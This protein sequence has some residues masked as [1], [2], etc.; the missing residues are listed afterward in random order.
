MKL[1]FVFPGQGSQSVGMLSTLAESEP[2]VAETFAEASAVLGYDLWALCARGPAE[3]LNATERTQPALLAAGAAAWR[4]WRA[5]GGREPAVMAGHSLG[6][7]TAL[8]C[9]GALQFGEAVDLV[10]F[11]GEAMQAAVPAGTG[12]MAAI[13]GLDDGA[14]EAACAEAAGDEVVVAVNY[15]APGQVVI[16]GTADAVKRAIE[17]CRRRGAKR[18][19]ELPVSVPS[20]SPLMR[21]AAERFRDRLTRTSLE[22]PRIPVYAFDAGR[23]DSAEAIRDGLYRQLINPVRW[24]SIVAAMIG[25]GVTH[26]VEAGPGRVLSG[27][28]RRAE[29]GRELSI[30]SL[31]STGSLE[32]ALAGCSGEEG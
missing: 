2:I 15:N 28:V 31:D 30:H 13:L 8:V 22:A 19:V 18:A 1:A 9:A 11:R 3:D 12:A 24:S 4:T 25:E 32:Q 17:A 16:A 5:R 27:L 26:V 20:H 14:V 6:E 29:G 21:P 23:H 7:I 10:R